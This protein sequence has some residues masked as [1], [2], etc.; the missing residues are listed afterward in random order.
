[1]NAPLEHRKT[2]TGT[3]EVLQRV[4]QEAAKLQSK[5]WQSSLLLFKL[6][7]KETPGMGEIWRSSSMHMCCA[8]RSRNAVSKNIMYRYVYSRH[9][10]TDMPNYPLQLPTAKK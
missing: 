6:T 7:T 2:V 1:M 5:I 9:T 3:K 4:D 10:Y 8:R